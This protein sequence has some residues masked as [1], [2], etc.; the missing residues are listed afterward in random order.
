LLDQ[1]WTDRLPLMDVRTSSQGGFPGVDQQEFVRAWQ[2]GIFSVRD[3]RYREMLRLLKVWSRYWQ[4][5]FLDAR[6]DRLFRLG[7]A[8]MFWDGSWFAS[9]IARAPM[10]TFRFGIFRV[11]PL[12]RAS[13]PYAPAHPQP[14]VH[15]V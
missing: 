12:S 7:R 5:G 4:P 13:S 9:Q 2:K 6:D 10:R 3:P 11:P 1:L 8:A 14:E 15:G